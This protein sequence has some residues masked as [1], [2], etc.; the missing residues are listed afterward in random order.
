MDKECLLQHKS[1]PPGSSPSRSFSARAKRD[2]W[3]SRILSSDR[4][5]CKLCESVAQAAA[6]AVVAVEEEEE[7]G[8]EAVTRHQNIS[9]RE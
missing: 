1:K 3:N 7:E 5:S 4:C 6:A 9:R 2:H 8:E